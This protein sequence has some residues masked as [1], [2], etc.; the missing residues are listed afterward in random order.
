[1]KVWNQE[2]TCLACSSKCNNMSQYLYFLP[3][4]WAYFMSFSYYIFLYI[5]FC[6][7]SCSTAIVTASCHFSAVTSTSRCGE[8]VH[9]RKQSEWLLQKQ[10]ADDMLFPPENFKWCYH[11][12]LLTGT[13]LLWTLKVVWLNFTV[14]PCI[15][16][17]WILHTN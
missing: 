12:H 6:I 5:I 4:N 7:S 1:V 14:S 9:S 8:N 10:H 16:I 2:F 3:C 15:L 13:P 11:A 17:H